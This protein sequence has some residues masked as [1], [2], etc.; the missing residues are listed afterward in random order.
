MAVVSCLSISTLALEAKPGGR[1]I[2]KGD[3]GFGP[4]QMRAEKEHQAE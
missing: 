1:K 2:E 3:V 4:R